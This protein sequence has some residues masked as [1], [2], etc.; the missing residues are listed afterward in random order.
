M[1]VNINKPLVETFA[2]G[3]NFNLAIL[4]WYAREGWK[5]TKWSHLKAWVSIS[6]YVLCIW[7]VL[8]TRTLNPI[9]TGF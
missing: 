1:S 3:H 2:E 5:E 6:I 4:C 8:N 9:L 7:F